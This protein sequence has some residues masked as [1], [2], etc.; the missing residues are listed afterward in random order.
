MSKPAFDIWLEAFGNLLETLNRAFEEEPTERARYISGLTA[1]ATFVSTF[2]RP[3]GGHF[4]ELAS[5]LVDLEKG[6]D[7]PLF[8]P[9]EIWD[10]HKD[11]S[12][13]WRAKARIVLAIEALIALDTEPGKAEQEIAKRL[14]SKVHK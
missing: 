10:R 6:Q 3:I 2:N 8:E 9:A 4:F 5:K 1:L 14:G 13:R 7:N 12:Q 11:K